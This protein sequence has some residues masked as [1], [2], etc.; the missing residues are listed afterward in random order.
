MSSTTSFSSFELVPPAWLPAG[1]APAPRVY[2]PAIV[3]YRDR[4]LMA[5]RVDSGRRRAAQRQIGLCELDD[6]LS[7]VP[8]SIVNVSDSI[9]GG[10][11]RHYDPRFLVYRERL[12]I[13]YNNNVQ[14]HPNRIY[15]VELDADTLEARSPPLPV[16]LQ[17]PR[18]DIE[19]NW[20][21][22]EHDGDLHAVYWIAPHT[23]LRVR[24]DADQAVECHT[25]H[26]TAWDVSVYADRYG[27]PRGGTPPSRQGDL[28]V[29][30]FHSRRPVGR[31]HR[32][33]RYWP[34]PPGTRLPR[35][36]AAIER[37][38]R[39][40]FNQVR[41]AAGAYA[42]EASPPFRPVWLHP[43]PVLRPEDEA[44]RQRRMRANPSADGIVY[45]CGAIPWHDRSWLVSYGLHDETCCLRSVHLPSLPNPAT[46]QVAQIGHRW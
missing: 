14:T 26:T 43:T 7:I 10:S 2:N 32:M 9:H 22:F 24:L 18:Q 34:V 11:P 45:P 19:K 39:R 30:F 35:Y 23:I 25:V 40:P 21:F 31:L 3:K 33:L 6:Q 20:M 5:Y 37:R 15:L 46:Q 29:S 17:G 28:Y 27:A 16:L 36:A 1:S 44:P 13:H 8:G 4:L 42:F 12:Y 38:L 41:Y